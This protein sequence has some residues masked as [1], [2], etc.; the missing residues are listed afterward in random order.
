MTT[1]VADAQ[2]S[3]SATLTNYVQLGNVSFNGGTATTLA[4]VQAST[5]TAPISLSGSA[6]SGI[7][8]SMAGKGTYANKTV[9]VNTGFKYTVNGNTVNLTIN[10]VQLVF[11]STG[12]LTAA[13][14]PA[15]S[16]YSYTLKGAST[17]SATA[18]NSTADSLFSNGAVNLS[19]NT[20]LTKLSGAASLNTTQLNAYTPTP[21]TAVSATLTI[22]PVANTALVLGDTAGASVSGSVTA[23]VK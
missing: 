14:I 3:T 2:N 18:T 19:I 6:L 16:S 12:A 23:N 17:A 13:T 5:P 7:Q 22:S 11:G 1:A 21:N 4:A 8:I 10:N 20:F 9:A 15:G